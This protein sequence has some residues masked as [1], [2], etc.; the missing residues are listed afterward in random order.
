ML[1]AVATPAFSTTA[2][3]LGDVR[4]VYVA[5]A[6]Q[7]RQ[8]LK[9]MLKGSEWVAI[10]IE[11]APVKKVAKRI[12]DLTTAKA[13]LT[14]ALK[15]MKRLKTAPAEI[16]ALE[17]SRARVDDGLKLARKAG[18]DPRRARIRLLQ[19]Y[20]G[21]DQV[22]V[23][24]LDHTRAGVLKLLDGVNIIA[25]NAAFELAFLEHAGV[26]LGEMHCTLQA[27]RLTLGEHASGLDDAAAHYFGLK[28]DKALQTSDWNAPSLAGNRSSMRR[29]TRS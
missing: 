7:A 1:D 11:T 13:E 28:L 25:H 2:E 20:D 22:L 27:C 6:P 21:G 9:A 15:A 12:E 19:V 23:I 26:A 17:N 8:L 5:E 24:D 16:E 29:S 4:V 10:D 3:I 18:L 14:G